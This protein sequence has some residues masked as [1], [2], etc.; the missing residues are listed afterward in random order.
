MLVKD[1]KNRASSNE[2]ENLLEKLE[3]MTDNAK[4]TYK[5]NY[6]KYFRQIK[7]FLLKDY[8]GTVLQSNFATK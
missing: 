2:L 8:I 1:Q 4:I 6:Y 7:M 3:K 5:V